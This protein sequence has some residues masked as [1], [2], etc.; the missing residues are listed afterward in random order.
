MPPKKGKKGKGKA[1]DFSP[2]DIDAFVKSYKTF[3]NAAGLPIYEPLVKQLNDDE[4]R[5]EFMQNQQLIIHPSD[6]SDLEE[7]RL[8]PGGC[9][10][11]CTSILA[12]APMAPGSK[13]KEP[14]KPF[15]AVKSIRCWHS[16][17]GDDGA[18]ALADVLRL[19]GVEVQL[20]YLEIID[21]NAW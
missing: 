15:K 17:I 7:P 2:E 8:G 4:D 6:P 19:G 3:S 10:A 9:R 5:E 18:C 11:L 1:P 20:E 12:L 14:E 21:N 13:P 16:S